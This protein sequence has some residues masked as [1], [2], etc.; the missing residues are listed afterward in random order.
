MNYRKLGTSG[1]MVPELSL[2]AGLFV[3]D[4][5]LPKNNVNPEQARR[6]VDICLERGAAMFDT[7]HT[8]WD[9][10]SE[11]ILGA[12][13]KGRRQHAIVSTKA[14][15]AVTGGGPNDAGASRHH[16]TRAIEQSLRRLDT[17]YIDV[18]QLHAHDA[19]TPPE[20]T[21]ATLDDCVRA[22]KIRY[23]GVSNM[24]G[25][26]LMKA[27]ATADRL[28]LPRYVVHQVYYSLIGRDYEWDL[29]P[30]ARD[31]GLSAS[32]WSPLG[33]GRLT[34]R[35]QRGQPLPEDSRLNWAADMGPAVE[36][37][38]LFRVL[39][40]L[41]AIADETGRL[42][43]Q[44][45]VNWLLQ[46]PTVATVILGARTEQQL[47]QSLE[48]AGW[49]LSAEQVARLDAASAVKPAYPADFYARAATHRNPPAV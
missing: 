20:E 8:Y 30:L 43:P 28:A 16:L 41:H 21:L 6:L 27:L 37:E 36:A 25:W 38:H 17:D 2:G 18:F 31:Q 42:V 34:G 44:I 4:G 45:A 23:V 47:L 15:Q 7:S 22:G 48:S 32:V 5:V 14:G 39:D 12:A 11:R 29:M 40:A 1:F 13:L 3:P 46:R 9:G 35:L 10:H 26:A 49:S 19:L 33:W 24:P